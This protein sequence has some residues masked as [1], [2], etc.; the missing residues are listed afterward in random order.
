MEYSKKIDESM[1]DNITNNIDTALK[2]VYE[3]KIPIEDLFSKIEESYDLS[4]LIINAIKENDII[5]SFSKLIKTKLGK[6]KIKINTIKDV[7]FYYNS[8]IAQI[9][10]SET[11]FHIKQILEIIGYLNFDSK[12]IKYELMNIPKSNKEKIQYYLIDKAKSFVEKNLTS[13]K[14]IYDFLKVN[15]ILFLTDDNFQY[16]SLK[17]F[18]V[19]NDFIY[20]KYGLFSNY[21]DYLMNFYYLYYKYTQENH[22]N[23]FKEKILSKIDEDNY[24]EFSLDKKFINEK[25][26]TI[27]LCNLNNLINN[28]NNF[29]LK[30]DNNLF[31]NPTLLKIFNLDKID[32]KKIKSFFRYSIIQRN[33]LNFYNNKDENFAVSVDKLDYDEDKLHVFNIFFLIACGLYDKIETESLQIFNFGNNVINLFKKYANILLEKI[34]SIVLDIK[35]NNNSDLNDNEFFGFGKIFNTFY[36]LYSNLNSDKYTEE[37]LKFNLIDTLAQKNDANKPM[38]EIKFNLDKS[39]VDSNF[40]R[41]SVDSKKNMNEE[42]IYH[43]KIN[44]TSLEEEC[45]T[46]ILTKINDLINENSDQI[47]MIEIYKILFGMNFYIPYIDE[48]FDLKFIPTKKQL[49]NINSEYPEYGYQ[50]FDYL[51]KVIG[52]E[53]ILMNQNDNKYLPF[54]SCLQININ[55]QKYFNQFEYDVEVKD[56]QP[57]LIKKNALVIVENKLKFPSQKDKIVELIKIMVKKLN[58]MIKL[59]KNTTKDFY[60]YDNIQLLL[61]YDDVIVKRDELKKLI[62]EEQIKS[63]L[64]SI[65]FK[66]RAKF[67][68]EIIY[69]SQTLNIYNIS[70]YVDKINKMEAKINKLEKTLHEHGWLNEEK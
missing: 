9:N 33:Y 60:S 39:E 57:F 62:S 15:L 47:Q 30:I 49:N 7:S 35:K 16:V 48:N 42:Q 51:F 64:I 67:S 58:F 56:N 11:D 31:N 63:I 50:E 4:Y 26:I 52:N 46:Y 40:S 38:F 12:G 32:K 18:L 70:K 55:S 10:N 37:K 44:A 34:N 23:E 29:K 69:I 25:Y 53:D 22:L 66:E 59:I 13:N 6:K 65:P 1:L 41:I 21:N 14:A 8:M 24:A 17:F 36:V 61:I 20:E 3:R 27:L 43:E 2:N 19:I 54:V 45:K 68:V 28:N 5:K